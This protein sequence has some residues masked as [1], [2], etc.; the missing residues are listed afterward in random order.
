MGLRDRWEER[1]IYL[2]GWP[3]IS[4]AP[5]SVRDSQK[6]E[7]ESD[8]GRHLT[9]SSGLLYTQVQAVIHHM[10]IPHKDPESLT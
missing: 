5:L 1:Q 6:N 7:I 4:L 9:S 2:W 10:N 8:R 3:A